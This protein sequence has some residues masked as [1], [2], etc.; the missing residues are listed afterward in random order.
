MSQLLALSAGRSR[1]LSFVHSLCQPISGH[2]ARNSTWQMS[3]R[4]HGIELS[5]KAKIRASDINLL[6][7][8]LPG[9]PLL[10]SVIR[11]E[12]HLARFVTP[13]HTIPYQKSHSFDL[14]FPNVSDYA[15]WPCVPCR[16]FSLSYTMRQC[17]LLSQGKVGR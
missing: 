13:L 5:A 8:H 1:Q 15:F 16:S 11:L 17:R 12:P 3:P 2:F 4:A 6:R 7:T 10:L 14:S 9:P